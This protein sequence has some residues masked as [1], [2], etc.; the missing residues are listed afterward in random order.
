MQS[1]SLLA[2]LSSSSFSLVLLIG[3]ALPLLVRCCSYCK[4]CQ[5]AFNGPID[6]WLLCRPLRR[7]PTPPPRLTSSDAAY[8]GRR[9][10]GGAVRAAEAQ[11]THSTVLREGSGHEECGESLRSRDDPKGT[12][13][14]WFFQSP[15]R[16]L[17]V[18]THGNNLL[19]SLFIQ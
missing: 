4:C 14:S 9:D 17:A 1:S 16:G 7:L 2:R 12:T 19:S 13:T 10:Q 15:R 3:I 11:R 18:L 6:G 5:P 8:E